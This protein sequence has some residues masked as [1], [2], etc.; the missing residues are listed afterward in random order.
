MLSDLRPHERQVYSQFGEDGVLEHIFECIGTTNRR[1]V[2]F[3]AKD[4]VSLSN[5]ANLRLHHGWTGLL[6]DAAASRSDEL[7]SHA[8]I[9]AEN[10][11]ALFAKH[12]VP[13][14][15]DLLSIDIDGNDYWVWKAIDLFTPR[16]VVIEYN[17][18]F[19]LD[20]CRTMPYDAQHVWQEGSCYHGASLA[21]LRKLGHEKGYA[22][23]HTDA[24]AP[25]AFFVLRSELPA[26]WQDRPTEELTDWGR[27]HEPP[28]T[29]GRPW[30]RV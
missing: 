25:N 18:F 27:F 28:G 6:M 30:T 26:D 5:T 11:N 1:F 15:F 12:G 14:R 8:F 21:A 4:G 3:G 2:E 13:E 17:I 23:V 7:V 10:V 29:E 22:L 9:D 24:W 19:Q 20:D 16:V